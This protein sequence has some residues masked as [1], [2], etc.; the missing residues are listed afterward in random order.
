MLKNFK[1]LGTRIIIKP[2][3]KNT[4]INGIIYTDDSKFVDGIVIS[5]SEHIKEPFFKIGDIVKYNKLKS[6]EIT[7]EDYI[8]ALM[9]HEAVVAILNEI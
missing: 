7:I 4:S 1:P 2:I 8:Y 6:E 5:I 9:D 3:Q